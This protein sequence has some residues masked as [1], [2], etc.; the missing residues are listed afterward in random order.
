[1]AGERVAQPR[2]PRRQVAGELRVVLG[3]AGARAE[4]LLPDRAG[5]PL[6][7]R[8][9]RG[10][11]VG[12]V[13]AGAHHERGRTRL[14]E[15]AGQLRHGLRLGVAPLEQ[16]HRRG[17]RALGIRRLEPV[18]HRHDHERG[19]AAGARLVPSPRQRAGHV[20]RARRLLDP[21]RVVAG[22]P[23]SRPVRNGS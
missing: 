3:E 1:M 13:G 19:A 11:A 4:R 21:D 23:V 12:R 17:V 6:G 22:Q 8:R 9:E 15:Q 14:G 16:P 2:A 20:L 18:V 7:E 5:E 10:P